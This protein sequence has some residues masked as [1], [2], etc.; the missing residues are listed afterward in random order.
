[1]K[2]FNFKSA[3]RERSSLVSPCMHRYQV[4]RTCGN[5][6]AG[7]HTCVTPYA[8]Q[9]EA[10]EWPSSLCRDRAR[11]RSCDFRNGE[12][13]PVV[14]RCGKRR[15]SRVAEE[16]V[17]QSWPATA[18]SAKIDRWFF[19]RE[20]E[21]LAYIVGFFYLCAELL[22]L[23]LQMMIHPDEYKLSKFIVWE[24]CTLRRVLS[25][26]IEER[27]IIFSEEKLHREVNGKI[28]LHPWEY[29]NFSSLYRERGNH[30]R[31][32]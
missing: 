24:T 26:G 3:K 6:H 29:T 15:S 30:L 25:N 9:R 20:N 7:T 2:T 28:I 11:C 5:V 13:P 21:M 16:I 10:R 23:E 1:M 22:R 32:K 8:W 27:E 12:T 19:P 14:D 18:Q 17:G 31:G 4:L